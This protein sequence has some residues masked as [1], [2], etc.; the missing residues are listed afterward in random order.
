MDGEPHAFLLGDS[1]DFAYE[2]DQ[3]GAQILGV[4][5]AI[6]REA[7]RRKLARS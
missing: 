3:V 7:P 6:A 1:R 5:I 4:D 2:G